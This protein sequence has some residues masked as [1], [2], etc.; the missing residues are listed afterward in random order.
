MKKEKVSLGKSK[1]NVSMTKL[2]TV[3]VGSGA[4][5]LCT[6]VELWKKGVRDIAILTEGLEMGTSINTGSDKQTYY[7]LAMCGSEADS[8]RSMAESYF[9]GGSMHGDLA[10][11]ESTLSAQA[12]LNL[13]GLGVP[14]PHDEFGQIVGYKTDHD[15]RQRGTSI[16][17]YTSRE[18]CRALIREAKSLGI[19]ILEKKFVVELLTSGK[20]AK[21]R[22]VGVVAVDAKCKPEIYLADN[23]VFGVGGPG[24]IYK[25][26]VYPNVHTG[27]IG[28]ALKAGAKA[29]SLPESQYG[30]ASTKFRW[31]VS[32]TYMQV[33]PRFIS[34]DA[35]GRPRARTGP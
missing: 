4:A 28:I 9:E 34:T 22:T 8:P 12:F 18:M 6:A 21:K 25:T 2:N 15:P 11:V 7:K 14:F 13:V 26:S 35:K 32:G 1:G 20:G 16:G 30:M 24:G 5:G 33:V 29:Q 31:N 27:A 10:M 3:I 17:P 19:P 23:V